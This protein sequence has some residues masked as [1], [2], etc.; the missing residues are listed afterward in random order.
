[1][2]GV[3][4]DPTPSRAA[5]PLCVCW[6]G[7]RDDSVAVNMATCA[8][9]G[10]GAR[11][12]I[13]V[14]TIAKVRRAHF[15]DKKKIKAIARELRLSRNTVRSIVRAEEE[16]ERRYQRREQPMPQ[17]GPYVTALAGDADGQ[18]EA[19]ETRASDLSADVR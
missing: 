19:A 18:R 16:T 13:T 15:V 5:R 8:C 12:M 14:D 17:L 11:G 1:M 3:Q 2:M 6:M 10:T 4:L 7:A 9:V